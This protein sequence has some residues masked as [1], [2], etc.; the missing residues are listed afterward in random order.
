MDQSLIAD[1]YLLGKESIVD[2]RR[3][4]LPAP[5]DCASAWFHYEWDTVL[6][7]GKKHFAC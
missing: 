7:T 6:R 4:F 5:N 2:F 3:L 1:A